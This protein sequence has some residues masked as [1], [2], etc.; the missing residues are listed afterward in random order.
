[1][2]RARHAALLTIG[3]AIVLFGCASHP[4]QHQEHYGLGRDATGA[5]IAKL[6]IDVSPDGT[7]LPNGRA[8]PQDGVATYRRSCAACHGDRLSLDRWSHA[9]SLFDYIR[10]AMPPQSPRRLSP[11]ELYGVTAYLLYADNRI[12]AHDII[13][14]RSLVHFRF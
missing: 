6:D 1:M 8:T 4:A 2:H 10:R 3:V 14:G 9:T 12:G 11:A 5:A 13:D 7:N